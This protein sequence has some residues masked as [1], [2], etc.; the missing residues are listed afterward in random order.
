MLMTK[1]SQKGSTM[2]E[3]LALLTIISIFSVFLIKIISN[4]YGIFK[5]SMA[6]Y[7]IKD[8]QK[9]IS[10]VYNFAGDYKILF[11]GVDYKEIL[12]KDKSI[13][14][15]MCIKS[16]SSYEIKHRLSGDVI[17]S[18][19]TDFKSYTIK[20]D[21]L[22]KKNCIEFVNINWL[23][24]KKVDIYQLDI[25]DDPVAYFP[26]KNGKGFPVEFST[27]FNKCTKEDKSNTVIWYFY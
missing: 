13:P 26:I 27:S 22:S 11:D 15:Q 9:G 23:D 5:Q 24:K 14:S 1:N 16:G 7:E 19:S 21:G 17:I 8:V 6:I 25:N 12:C 10:G 3:V 2:M 20:V 4:V 18:P